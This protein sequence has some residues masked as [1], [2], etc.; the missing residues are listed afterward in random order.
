MK[1][2]FQLNVFNQK[3]V[4]CRSSSCV[5]CDCISHHRHKGQSAVYSIQFNGIPKIIQFGSFSNSFSYILLNYE[6][7]FFHIFRWYH[8]FINSHYGRIEAATDVSV[9]RS[10]IVFSWNCFITIIVLPLNNHIMNKMETIKR[11]SNQ[12]IFCV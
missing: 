1:I 9:I 6:K 5:T 2:N 10:I 12:S 7:N 11:I 4:S 3:Y 8:H